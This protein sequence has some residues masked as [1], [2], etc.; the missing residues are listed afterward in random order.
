[1]RT[2]LP[3]MKTGF[4]LRELTY[5]EFPVSL[6]VFGFAV[7][8][9]ICNCCSKYSGINVKLICS[10]LLYHLQLYIVLC[11][12]NTCTVYAFSIDPTVQCNSAVY[13]CSVVHTEKQSN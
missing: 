1:M 12:A 8:L 11:M 2:G 9:H 10:G 3:V 7:C 4:S 6:T 13:I 5:R